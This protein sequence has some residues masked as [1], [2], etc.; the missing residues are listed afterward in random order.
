MKHLG[1]QVQWK[2]WGIVGLQAL[3]ATGPLVVDNL[4]TLTLAGSKTLI[5]KASGDCCVIAPSGKL[6]S[7]GLEG[8]G[9]LQGSLRNSKVLNCHQHVQEKSGTTPANRQKSAHLSKHH[10]L[11]SGR[12][13]QHR[14]HTAEPDS[15]QTSGPMGENDIICSDDSVTYNCKFRLN[16]FFLDVLR[17]SKAS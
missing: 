9:V 1:P 6:T 13:P 5:L 12:S 14:G 16:E 4:L 11:G 10:S 17:F 3:S 8:G 15:L 2:T 7:K